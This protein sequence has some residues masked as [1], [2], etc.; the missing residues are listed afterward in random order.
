MEPCRNWLG[1]GPGIRKDTGRRLC[2]LDPGSLRITG[3]CARHLRCRSVRPS[4]H[5]RSSSL[6]KPSAVAPIDFFR[7]FFFSSDFREVR[8][9]RAET[10]EGRRRGEMSG[11]EGR[12]A[13]AC[14]ISFLWAA[15]ALHSPAARS[16]ATSLR[17][18]RATCAALDMPASGLH[19]A[20]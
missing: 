11:A 17:L 6:I 16:G 15:A 1:T 13:V 5:P 14:H 8:V 10:V 3:T 4:A 20:R 18:G 2:P 9:L 7:S 12:P 19:T